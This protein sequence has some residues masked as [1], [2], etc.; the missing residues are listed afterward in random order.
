MPVLDLAAMP[1]GTRV[2]L[3]TNV[4]VFHYRGKSAS[5][6]ALINRIAHGDVIGYV[7]TQVLSDLLHKLMLAE[8]AAKKFC[9][10]GASDL[11]HWLSANRALAVQLTD[12]QTRFEDT[13]DL[14]IKVM[15]IT[16][17][18]L[19]D[20]KIERAAY[21]L[22]TGDSLHLGNMNR[23]TPAV[24]HIATHDGDFAHVPGL[25]VWKP[26]DVIR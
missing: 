8:A 3:D 13:L 24:R 9:G 19:V 20:T 14:G 2:F 21:G 15:R 6:T 1:S 4:F 17:N 11:K 12:Y 16:K 10:F 7:N 26:M 25:T 22:M 5:C 23:H 18:I